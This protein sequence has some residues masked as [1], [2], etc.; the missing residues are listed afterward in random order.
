MFLL[1]PGSKSLT[2]S[3]HG[4]LH[5]DYDYNEWHASPY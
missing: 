5:K 1:E 3:D 2:L 4:I